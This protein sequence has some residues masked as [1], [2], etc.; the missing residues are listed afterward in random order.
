M[1][2][3]ALVQVSLAPVRAESS[4]RAEI[5]TQLL[6]GEAVKV[7]SI[8]KPW[9][10]IR[11]HHDDYEGYMDYK[12]LIPLN[13]N[14]AADWLKSDKIRLRQRTLHINTPDGPDWIYQGSILPHGFESGFRLGS[15]NFQPLQSLNELARNAS[16]V[17]LAQSYLNTPYIWGGRSITGIDC[18]GFT[19]VIFAMIGISLKRDA[20]EQVEMGSLVEFDEVKAGDLAFF[21]NSKGNIIHVGIATGLGTILH[22]SGKVR[23]DKLDE[24]GIY[25]SDT[26]EYSH[27]LNCIKRIN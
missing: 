2:D 12:Q 25:R 11:C 22:A 16:I 15:L 20:S 14:D 24:K 4:D 21:H 17:E 8:E 1:T 18:S 5:V 10:H 7:I 26:G 19:Q 23:E 27:Q 3:F 9:V 13:T 6:F